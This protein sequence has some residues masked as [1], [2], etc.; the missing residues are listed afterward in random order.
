MRGKKVL[1]GEETLYCLDTV[2]IQLQA[3]RI[4][5]KK[6]EGGNNRHTYPSKMKKKHS[7]QEK[8]ETF[9]E[10]ETLCCLSHWYTTNRD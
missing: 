8:A 9:R 6:Q 7:S 2:S 3:S 4:S 1:E 5:R 10:G